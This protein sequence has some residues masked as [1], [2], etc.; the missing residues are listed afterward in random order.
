MKSSDNQRR[1][2]QT[3]MNRLFLGN[4][5]FLMLSW[6]SL[7]SFLG[8]ARLQTWKTGILWCVLGILCFVLLTVAKPY[9]NRAAQF[10]FFLFVLALPN[11]CLLYDA[12]LRL[13]LA[14]PTISAQTGWL[15]VWFILLTIGGLFAQVQVWRGRLR[16]SLSK[17]LKSNRLSIEKGYWDFSKPLYIDDST[18]ESAEIKR[19]NVM[20]KASPIVTALSLLFAR[21]VTGEIQM[22]AAAVGLYILGCTI[23]WGYGKHLAIA[24]QIKEWERLHNIE[25]R[26]Q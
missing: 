1:E 26:I 23:I 10:Y 20:S 19:W 16:T 4:L 22:L 5:L 6:M 12:T 13:A 17:N 11:G 9:L 21:A 7:F 25:I 15:I 3:S 14:S 2:M 24:L 18:G 8:Y